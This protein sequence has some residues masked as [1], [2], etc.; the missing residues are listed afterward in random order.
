MFGLRVKVVHSDDQ[1]VEL[2]TALR[3]ARGP[4]G[5]GGARPRRSCWTSPGPG[6]AV[7]M[8][9]DRGGGEAGVPARPGARRSVAG[10]MTVA[11]ASAAVEREP[12]RRHQL[13]GSSAAMRRQ[14]L[15]HEALGHEERGLVSVGASWTSPATSARPAQWSGSLIAVA[16]L[17]GA[18]C[19]LPDASDGRGGRRSG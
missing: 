8:L 9:A 3:C 16:A 17:S 4:G 13:G 18:S 12:H 5:S 15:G 19:R 10:G 6:L 14:A 2:A 11:L 1:I 7:E